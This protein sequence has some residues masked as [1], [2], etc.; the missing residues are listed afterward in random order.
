MEGDTGEA[1]EGVSDN[2]N[3]SLAHLK[4]KQVSLFENRKKLNEANNWSSSL[5]I[6]TQ[7]LLQEI[8]HCF[9]SLDAH[10][11]V[12]QQKHTQAEA[13]SVLLIKG[14]PDDYEEADKRE[15]LLLSAR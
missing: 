2:T 13:F 1:K 7:F 14:I 15:V 5:R 12:R 11:S 3:L 10:V 9:K 8:S 4:C 6:I